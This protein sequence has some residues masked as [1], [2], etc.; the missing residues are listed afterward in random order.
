MNYDP[1]WF[2][3]KVKTRSDDLRR[4]FTDSELKQIFFETNKFRT[5][6]DNWKYY[7]PRLALLTG[8]RLNELAQLRVSDVDLVTSLSLSIN[9]VGNDKRTK[10]AASIRS[11]CQSN[12]SK[13]T[14]L[15]PLAILWIRLLTFIFLLIEVSVF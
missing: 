8:C 13:T 10:N 11:I 7:L 3:H 14:P 6:A 5:T 1:S 9:A 4:A 15:S 2:R 12:S